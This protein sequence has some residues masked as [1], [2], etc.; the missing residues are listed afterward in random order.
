M[1]DT[2]KLAE[3][4]KKKIIST[5]HKDIKYFIVVYDGPNRYNHLFKSVLL[6]KYLKIETKPKQAKKINPDLNLFF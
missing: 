1:P 5:V 2:S 3:K 4:K 6:L